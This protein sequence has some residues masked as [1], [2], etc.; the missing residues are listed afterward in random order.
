MLVSKVI[1]Y[2][3]RLCAIL[4]VAFAGVLVPA[5]LVADD[6]RLAVLIVDGHNN[7]DWIATTD[8]VHAA[9]AASGRF[10]VSVETAPALTVAS[11]LRNRSKDPQDI[12]DE[13]P[14]KERYNAA[15][16]PLREA[17]GKTWSEWCPDFAAYDVVVLNYNGAEWD[18]KTK[19]ALVEYVAQGGGLILIHAANNA[20]GNWDEYNEMIGL[21]WRPA[22]FGKAPKVDPDTGDLIYFDNADLPNAGA[23]SHGSKHSFQVA[24]RAPDHPVMR[25]VPPMW[26]HARD[27]LYH[28]MRGPALN[29]TVLS[30]AY[31][32]PAQR[33]SGLHEPLTWEV[34]YGKGRVIVTSMGHI[35]KGDSAIDAVQCVG[36]QTIVARA[37]EYV[38][39]GEVSLPIPQGFPT[40]EEESVMPAS[41]VVW[42][43]AETTDREPSAAELS[44]QDKKAADPYCMLSP[45]EEHATFRL[46]PGY[47][48]ELAA[49]EPDVVEPVLTVWDGNGAMYVAEMRSYMQDEKGTGT[50][51]LR[52]GRIKR[53]VDT[54]GDGRMDKV[55][56][57]VDNL[58]LPRAILPLDD[59]IA[60]RETDTMTVYCYRD[61]DGDG[62]ADEKTLL[63]DGGPVGRNGPDTS[64]EHQD[65]GLIWNLDNY[66]YVTYN[67]E[68]YRFTTGE[69]IAE[70]QPGHWTQWG[71]DRD[72]V[73]NLYWIANSDPVLYPHLH[74]RYWDIARRRAGKNIAGSRP[75]DLGDPYTQEFKTVVSLCELNDRG[76][77]VSAKRGFTSACGQSI[78]RGHKLPI[79]DRGRLFVADPTIHVVRRANMGDR[80]GLVWFDK[81]EPGDEE[82]LLSSDVN[83][84]FMNTA[85]GPDGTLYVTDMY[86]GIIQDA[87]WLSPDPRKNIVANGLHDNNQHGRIWR[88]RHQ[89]HVP[90][91]TPRMLDESTIELLRHLEHP[92]GWWRD[93]AQKLIIL[94]DDRDTVVP[95]LRDM[96]RFS[97]NALARLHALWT[98]EGCG[99]VDREFLKAIYRDRDERVRTAAIQVAE[100]LFSKNPEIITDL[101]ALA[102]DRSPTVAKQLLLSLGMTGQEGD[103]MEVMQQAAKPHLADRGVQVAA[104]VTMWGGN[105]LP[106]ITGLKDGSSFEKIP[107]DKRAVAKASF[108]AM[109]GNWTRGLKFPDSLP[110]NDQKHITSGEVLY[111]KSCVTCH[112]TDGKGL[113]V[114]GTDNY[115]APSL[116][117][118][119]RVHGDSK[120]LSPILLHGLVGPLDGVTYQ[121]GYMAPGAAL[122]LTR[123]RDI[124][125]VLSYI[126]YAWGKET[127]PIISE[128]EVRDAKSTH[129][130]RQAPWTQAELEEL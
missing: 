66:I 22:L 51:T 9:L 104:A 92:S 111:F 79:A 129:K 71:L 69:W 127:L 34:A 105:D 35:W 80:D 21:G 3:H 2:F 44:M 26:M 106:L 24:V 121:A 1:I 18:Q 123:E 95:L 73:G 31:S 102:S 109:I 46:Q 114:A 124:A 107:S 110:S 13:A 68:R 84:R 65:S 88:I 101:F 126:R 8:G 122:G 32:D 103:V 62:V 113:R 48:A 130:D 6:E 19:A 39:T 87:G 76:G 119:P 52:N 20:F 29:L 117:D 49:S 98:A 58:N 23:S 112:G 82:F 99:A 94:R 53:L 100:T 108:S 115:M 42:G 40:A 128:Q 28:N 61:T 77:A 85:H 97:D 27:E 5:N 83:S 33:G 38:A 37:C 91:K 12:A 17:F 50:K 72:D 89:D 90:G 116:I 125:Q 60:V 59:R 70:K 25:D 56:V 43:S 30:S 118:S 47:V 81:A 55:T 57:F 67:M 41:A 15:I 78:F 93:T 36:F 74:P 7:H 120:Q 11:G 4:S 16:K 64:V 86:R 63:F 96:A 45:E 54:N 14:A 75:I 10:D